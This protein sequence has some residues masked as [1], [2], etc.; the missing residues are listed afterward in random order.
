MKENKP[1]WLKN[2]IVLGQGS[3]NKIRKIQ[4]RQGRCLC[5]WSEERGLVRIYPVP[6]GYVHDWEIINVQLRLSPTDH[7]ENSFAVYNYEK[8]WNN[9]S[10]R[11]YA[12]T[13]INRLGNKMHKKL[14]R[15]KQI[16]LLEKISKSTY[17][18]IKKNKKS[19]GIIKPTVLDLVLKEN[20]E[21]ST[22][23]AT[24]FEN[25]MVIMDQKDFAF[26]PYLHFSCEGKC[27]SKHPHKQKIVEWGA[28]QWM[29]QKPDSKTH[30]EKLRDNYHITEKDYLHFVLIGNIRKYPN[31][32]Q[33]VK[34]FRF[35]N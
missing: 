26:L 13:R 35:K 15:T 3:P 11:I 4:G 16:G 14:T 18:E 17:S 9:L 2:L 33:V 25:D 29:R 34:L 7:R 8:E 28:Y 27:S 10:K 20:K 21:K 19:F 30:C 32:Y 24:L 22:A 12:Q 31:I 6:H 23:Q 5:V 1:F